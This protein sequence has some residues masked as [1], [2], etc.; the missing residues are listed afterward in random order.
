MKKYNMAFVDFSEIRNVTADNEQLEA[1]KAKM[2]EYEI[3]T[4]KGN[5]SAA[6]IN[7]IARDYLPQFFS[8]L[9]IRSSKLKEGIGGIYATMN[10]LYDRKDYMG[11]YLYL[12]IMYGFIQWRM[13]ERIELLP[14][15]TDALK[16]F[17]TAC[18]TIFEKYIENKSSD[19]E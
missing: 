8:R 12:A 11:L 4:P 13:P 3:L 9:D 1:A 19:K 16:L 6:V 14:A 17:C 7:S 18:L 2:L 10:K 5:P 15:S